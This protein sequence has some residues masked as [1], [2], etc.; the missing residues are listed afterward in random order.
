MLGDCPKPPSTVNVEFAATLT[1]PLPPCPTN[2]CDEFT[3]GP[4]VLI[5]SVPPP[6][7]ATAPSVACPTMTLPFAV[8]VAPCCTTNRPALWVG[9]VPTLIPLVDTFPED[10]MQFVPPVALMHGETF[11][12]ENIGGLGI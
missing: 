7:I 10:V 9:S 6:F 12:F 11:K 8:S 1:V 3:T 5:A 4:N 2:S